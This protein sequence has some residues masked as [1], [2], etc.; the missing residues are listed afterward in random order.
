MGPFGLPSVAALL[1]VVAWL[2]MLGVGV[3]HSAGIAGG[4]I[5]YDEAMGVCLCFV[6]VLLLL[7]LVH[8]V[9]VARAIRASALID[10]E[11]V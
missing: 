10:G 5:G 2:L 8:A 4:T 1:S 7:M 3:L 9:L 6:P 11:Q